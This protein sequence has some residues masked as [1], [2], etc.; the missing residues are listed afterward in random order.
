MAVIS[1]SGVRDSKE[2]AYGSMF[3]PRSRATLARRWRS[4]SGV[5]ASSPS[6]PSGPSEGAEGSIYD[7]FPIAS[8]S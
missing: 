5:C 3:S 4:H 1:P 8:T 7:I 2:R 6:P